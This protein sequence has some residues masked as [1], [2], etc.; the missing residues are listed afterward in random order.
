M[1]LRAV[2]PDQQIGDDDRQADRHHRLPQVLAGHL[3]EDQD[4]HRQPDDRRGGETGSDRKEPRSAALGDEEPDVAAEQVQRAVR[5]IDVAH[6]P[7]HQ[8]EPARDDEVQ[9]AERQAVEQ[10]DEEQPLVVGDRPDR[11]HGDRPA[12]RDPREPAAPPRRIA[13]LRRRARRGAPAGAA[14][15]VFAPSAITPPCSPSAS[16]PTRSAAPCRTRRPSSPRACRVG[17]RRTGRFDSGS[18]STSSRSARKPSFSWP[19][20]LPRIMISPPYF[21]ADRIASIGVMPEVLD[22]ELEVARVLAVRREREP[23][24]AAGQHADAALVHLRQRLERGIPLD[25][26]AHARRPSTA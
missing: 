5:E 6:Q 14:I 22:E 20:S 16:A 1:D 11:E 12:D 21:V 4:L 9:R 26:V 7:E 13:A 23:V 2:V 8:R 19:S 18:P 15:A 17:S 3:A 24:V 25:L 10:R